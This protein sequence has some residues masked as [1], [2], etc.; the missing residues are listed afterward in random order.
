MAIVPGKLY[1]LTGHTTNLYVYKYYLDNIGIWKPMLKSG[2]LI[3]INLKNHIGKPI[4]CVAKTNP[5][6]G[7]FLFEYD[8]VGIGISNLRSYE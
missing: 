7:I 8:N 3:Q 5:N 6:L 2:R 4:L 1:N